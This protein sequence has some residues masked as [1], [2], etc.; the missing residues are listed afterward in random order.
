MEAC[1]LKSLTCRDS[2]QSDLPCRRHLRRRFVGLAKIC[3]LL[4]APGFKS[5]TD[6]LAQVYGFYGYSV[7]GTGIAET[8][9]V[10]ERFVHLGN[11]AW[12]Y[13]LLLEEAN[14]IINSRDQGGP[15]E[16]LCWR[17]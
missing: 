2:T 15:H 7:S 10:I 9:G 11:L 13:N 4:G 16:R 8:S 17:D 14:L 5:F 12:L 6:L 1:S 3:A